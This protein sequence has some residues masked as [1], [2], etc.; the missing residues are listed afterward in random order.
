M[1]F[2][3]YLFI[4][5]FLL[6]SLAIYYI[7]SWKFKNLIL[8]IVSYIFYG[9]SNPVFILL[10]LLIT[11]GNYLSGYLISASSE[12][13][14]ITMFGKEIQKR[15]FI[16]VLAVIFNLAILG[17]F[18]YFNF[19]IDSFRMLLQLLHINSRFL[20]NVIRI[21]LPLG[22]SFFTFQAMSYTIDVYRKDAK[23]VKSFIDFAC[24][25][26]MF[27]QLVAG[28][29]IR[30]SEVNDQLQKRTLNTNKI[31]RGIV[32]LTFGLAKKIIFANTCAVIADATFNA[33]AT[34]MLDA[35]TGLFAYSFQ[36]YF[37]FSGYSDMAIGLGLIL[38]FVF[39][40]NFNSP[41]KSKSITEFWQRWHLSLSFWL[42]DYLYIPLGGNRKG[43]S[44]TYVNLF[45]V[46]LLGGLWHGAS[47]NFVIWGALHGSLLAIERKFFRTKKSRLPDWLTTLRTFLIVT[48][49]WVFFRCETLPGAMKYLATLFG[50]TGSGGSAMIIHGMFFNIY[51]ISLFFIAAIII[52]AAPQTW[53]YSMVINK[54]KT[55]SVVIVLMLS[56]FIMMAQSYNPFIYFIF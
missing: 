1:V 29:I 23:V 45:I 26:S 41:Y 39:P 46:M 7:V 11:G 15:K 37:D 43:L 25:V 30:F 44:R 42:R 40:K 32:F 47:W 56:I 33:N 5:I 27:P 8:T 4:F 9:W 55:A 35:W 19:G 16:L 31:A 2:S 48:L 49:I 52:W 50:L 34:N 24:Y 14:H 54:T 17:F 18:K 22:I 3:T 13:K 51:N 28:P 38:G 53:D 36:I 6:P 10:M 12:K 20:D 21:A